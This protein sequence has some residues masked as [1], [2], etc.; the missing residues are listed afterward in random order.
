MSTFFTGIRPRS[1]FE[2]YTHPVLPPPGFPDS[3]H[4]VVQ[5]ET[6]ISIATIE[7]GLSEYDPNLWRGI[8]IANG[9]TDPVGF[10]TPGDSWIGRTILIPATP[11]PAF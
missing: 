3:F 10:G 1:I 5:G 11:L 7:Y 2:K 9:I 8:M 4:L 6:L